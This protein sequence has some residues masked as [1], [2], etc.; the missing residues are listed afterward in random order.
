VLAALREH[1]HRFIVFVDDLSFEEHET[2]YKALK[3]AL[4]GGIEAWPGN[5]LLYVTTNRRHLVKERFA[6]REA[7]PSDEV[8]PRDTQEEK[9]SL[10]DRFGLLITFPAPDQERYLRIVVA[11][12]RERGSDLPDGELRRR[13]LQ[14]ALW[15]N[16]RTGRAARQFV[17][18]LQEVLT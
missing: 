1:P 2:G 13:A 16:G 11:L 4:E 14:W 6:D 7:E 15:H 12:A 10:A 5:A 18:D 17:D 3:A 9:L 8:R